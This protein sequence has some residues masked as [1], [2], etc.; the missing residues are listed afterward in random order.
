MS[1]AL[2][3]V[4]RLALWSL[5]L[6]VALDNV[7]VEVTALVATLGIGGVAL[8]LASH[9]HLAR[10]SRIRATVHVCAVWGRPE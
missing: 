5:L 9:A 7:G 8:A 1:A 2:R 10:R 6:V 3:H 4:G